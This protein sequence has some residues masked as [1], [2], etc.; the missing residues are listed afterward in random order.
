MDGMRLKFE[1]IHHVT[2]EMR[3]LDEEPDH[4]H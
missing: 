2:I 3:N 1:Y 4:G